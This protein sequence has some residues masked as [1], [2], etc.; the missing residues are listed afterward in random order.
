MKAYYSLLMIFSLTF[1]SVVDLTAALPQKGICA[2]R[3]ASFTHPENTLSAFKE[4]LRVGVQMI[5]FD[6]QMTKDSALVI[7]HDK[8]VDRTSNGTGQVAEMTLHQ[9]KKLDAGS[10]KHEAYTGEKIST[11]AEVLNI[12]PRN[13][14]LNV[15]IKDEPAVG[16]AVARVLIQENRL[17]QS[18]VAC[19]KEG[20]KAIQAFDRRV[21]ICNMERREKIKD[22]VDETIAMKA[23]FIQLLKDNIENLRPELQKLKENQIGINYSGAQSPEEV[24]KLLSA[25]VD[26]VLVD[27]VVSMMKILDEMGI[28]GLNP[29]VK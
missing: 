5:E 27:D 25:D 11:L 29:V 17:E 28:P 19:K 3:G 23:D 20:A 18:F 4:A 16:I 6:V 12:M 2:H 26:F 15:H 8:K 9:I 1:S 14:W 21:K 10:W 22:Y 13:I 24:K 7:I